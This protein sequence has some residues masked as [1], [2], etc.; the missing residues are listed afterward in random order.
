MKDFSSIKYLAL[1][2]LYISFA[3]KKVCWLYSTHT[4]YKF[5]ITPIYVKKSKQETVMAS[6]TS[7][8]P[9]PEILCSEHGIGF[10]ILDISR[11]DTHIAILSVTAKFLYGG[12]DLQ[13]L[14]TW[15]SSDGK[16]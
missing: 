10:S 11:N 9:E 5:N 7:R 14:M 4:L 12:H 1:Q 2:I 16:D 8:S 15:R 13:C 3:L 6:M